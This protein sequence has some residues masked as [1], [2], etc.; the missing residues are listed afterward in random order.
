[1]VYEQL[2]LITRWFTMIYN[3]LQNK[4]FS[5]LQP[6]I[7]AIIIKYNHFYSQLQ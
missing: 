7:T 2:Q 5:H 6:F 1:M 4:I 3:Q